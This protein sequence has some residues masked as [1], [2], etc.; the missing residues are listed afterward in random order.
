MA[1]ISVFHCDKSGKIIGQEDTCNGQ[2]DCSLRDQN[3]TVVKDDWS[4]ESAS[5]CG[6]FTCKNG[7]QIGK[8]LICNSNKDCT[9]ASDEDPFLCGQCGDKDCVGEGNQCQ[10][11]IDLEY[12]K[13]EELHKPCIDNGS[14]WMCNGKCISIED[15]CG[16]VC[17]WAPLYVCDA[18]TGEKFKRTPNVFNP[19]SKSCKTQ[20][21]ALE[22]MSGSGKAYC[23]HPFAPCTGHL[24]GQ[25]IYGINRNNKVYN[26]V[27][28]SDESIAS[29]DEQKHSSTI[30]Y[31]QFTECYRPPPLDSSSTFESTLFGFGMRCGQRKMCVPY[32]LWCKDIGFLASSYKNVIDLSLED[33]PIIDDKALCSN[34]TFWK[35]RNRNSSEA[36]SFFCK[37]YPGDCISRNNV[38]DNKTT[39]VLDKYGEVKME[40]LNCFDKSDEVC[41]GENLKKCKEFTLLKYWP[42]SY[43]YCDNNMTCV[44]PEL[45]C[46]GVY[47]CDDGSDE[48]PKKCG[49]DTCS[50]PFNNSFTKR[51]NFNPSSTFS[52]QSLETNARICA[53]LCDGITECSGSK[54]EIRC[55]NKYADI[56]YCLIFSAII[57]SVFWN[58]VVVRLILKYNDN[59]QDNSND[60][61][62]NVVNV[63]LILQ[64]VELLQKETFQQN[65]RDNAKNL[66]D[67]L[68]KSENYSSQLTHLISLINQSFKNNNDDSTHMLK[69]IYELEVELHDNDWIIADECFKQNLGTNTICQTV[70][71]VAHPGFI[72]S[73][74]PERLRH[75][76]LLFSKIKTYTLYMLCAMSARITLHYLDLGK[77][78]ILLYSIWSFVK[79]SL[80]HFTRFS[81]QMIFSYL[82]SI[83]LPLF[84]NAVKIIF[85][86][87]E[88]FYGHFEG[89][90]KGRFRISMQIMSLPFILFIPAFIIY[91][92]EKKKL[93]VCRVTKKM[94]TTI[95]NSGSKLGSIMAMHEDTNR[96]RKESLKLNKLL[97]THL[98]I[99]LFEVLFQTVITFI[100]FSMISSDTLT[101]S[102]LQ[103]FFETSQIW[104]YVG[105]ILSI[106]KLTW[107]N[108][109]LQKTRKDGFFG[110]FGFTIYGMYVLLTS[111]TRAL[112]MLMYFTIPMGLLNLLRHWYYETVDIEW[113]DTL[114][115]AKYNISSKDY[116]LMYI[117]DLSPE[118]LSN[119]KEGT[120]L[121]YTGFTLQKY[122][123]IFLCGILVHYAIMRTFFFF[124]ENYSGAAKKETLNV[125]T[126]HTKFTLTAGKYFTH[127]FASIVIPDVLEDWDE[128]NTKIQPDKFL[129]TRRSEDRSWDRSNMVESRKQIIK[130]HITIY[131][132]LKH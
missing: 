90:F 128:L 112:A 97:L 96:M 116:D 14:F 118:L 86:D 10:E 91:Q 24:P 49:T 52:C 18:F 3:E 80:I 113:D 124:K 107:V 132:I 23:G 73:I 2:I 114:T 6:Y 125:K 31:A 25:C 43:K 99:E 130:V 74:I 101:I 56:L 117:K 126:N 120:T 129:P 53:I 111:L 35:D 19:Y 58:E 104:F 57:I 62:Q 81:T 78:A 72:Q 105:I 39:S 76:L 48:D 84:I 85:F 93:L 34:H 7:N 68:H 100:A 55:R 61:L 95:Q 27:D 115:Y 28:R 20:E 42:R 30:D 71:D 82:A 60:E 106:K 64:L 22:Y 110:I 8:T 37:K 32:S 44:H 51:P 67:Q 45:V 83:I 36:C 103:G 13:W 94:V 38:C 127:V 29:S 79:P 122:Y 69:L 119:D 1:Y 66:M 40:E 98:K 16:D 41:S 12:A 5:L 70:M 46:D 123:I 47:N 33:C 92:N 59:H 11:Q 77:D 121:K 54:D 21:N 17:F 131:Y 9:D 63:S 65:D 89:E 102:G 50:T 26:C 109:S 108:I 4:D 75:V 88:D 15:P 87:L